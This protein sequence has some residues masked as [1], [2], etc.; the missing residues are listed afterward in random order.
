MTLTPYSSRDTRS[1][2]HVVWHHQHDRVSVI[3]G[4][5]T[6]TAHVWVHVGVT[7]PALMS[8]NVCLSTHQQCAVCEDVL[9]VMHTHL[10]GPILMDFCI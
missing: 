9:K 2:S 10:S 7:V 3:L 5:V 6:A 4:V 1:H 8:A